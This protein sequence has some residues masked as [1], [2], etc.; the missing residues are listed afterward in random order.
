MGQSVRLH[1]REQNVHF[2]LISAQPDHVSNLEDPRSLTI[3]AIENV[4]DPFRFT[5]VLTPIP[6]F[7]RG[8]IVFHRW[9]CRIDDGSVSGVSFQHARNNGLLQP[10]SATR[11]CSIKILCGT[12]PTEG[13]PQLSSTFLLCETK[14]AAPE[15]GWELEG[16]SVERRPF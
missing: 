12:T 11:L 6:R 16:R 5:L 15:A 10:A 3:N 4:E 8:R 1:P 13:H 14:L 2:S 7:G 9:T